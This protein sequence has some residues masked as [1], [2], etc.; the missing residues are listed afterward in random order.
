MK[1]DMLKFWNLVFMQYE[2]YKD[3]TGK[4][5]RRDLPKP[6]IDTGAGLERITACMQNVYWNY[7]V[8]TFAPIIKKLESLSKKKYSDP[9]VKTSM[10]VICDHIRAATMLITDGVLPSN[11]GERLCA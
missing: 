3:E 5:L 7:D 9:E 11:E 10:R 6:S 2:K 1:E 8:D 4:V